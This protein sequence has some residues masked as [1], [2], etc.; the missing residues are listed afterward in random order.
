MKRFIILILPLYLFTISCKK[1]KV[2][3]ASIDAFR[4]CEAVSSDKRCEDNVSAF[5]ATTALIF[6]AVTVN[7]AKDDDYLTISWVYTS[8]YYEIDEVSVRLGDYIQGNTA[9]IAGSLS[10]PTAG[11]PAGNYEVK[12]SLTGGISITR[13][14]SIQ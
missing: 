12:A 7:D 3:S 14:F 4:L 2:K 1:D 6:A 13:T 11:W 10:R 8:D 9:Q 5:D